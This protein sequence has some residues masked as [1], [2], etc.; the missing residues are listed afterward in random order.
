M[1]PPIYYLF[2]LVSGLSAQNDVLNMPV[3]GIIFMG[4]CSFL[5]A[6][7][8]PNS[9]LVLELKHALDYLEE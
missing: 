7:K 8:Q 3:E 6:R 2:G 9:K 1:K 5:E 4:W